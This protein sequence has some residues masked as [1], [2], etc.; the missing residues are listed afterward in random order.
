M[1]NFGRALSIALAHRLNVLI[2]V[3]TAVAVALLWGGNLTAVYPVV[4]V[5]MNDQSLPEWVD[6]A[7][8]ESQMEVAENSR[9][10]EQLAQLRSAEPEAMRAQIEAEITRRRADLAAMP[11]R[12]NTKGNDVQIAEKTRLKNSIAVLEGLSQTPA[13]E[14]KQKVA[15]ESRRAENQV[16]V[17]QLRAARFGWLAP[18]AHRWMP[19]TPFG[20]LMVVCLFVLICTLLRSVFRIWNSVVVARLGNLVGFDLRTLFYH[21]VLRLDVASFTEQGRG[22]LMNRCT[23]DLNSVNQGVQRLFGQTLLEPL[24]VLVCFCIAAYVSWRL[25][26]LTIIIAPLAGY[27][28]HWLGRALK[29]T[30]RRAMQ[31]LSLIY[32]TLAETLGGIKLIKAFTMEAAEKQRFQL[33]S[34][35]LYRRQMRIATYNSLVSP[36]VEALGVSMVLLASI[37][38]GY[39]VLGQHTHILGLKISD[40]ALTHGDMSVFFAMLAGMSDPARRLSNEF[41]HIQ[42]A[43]AAAD[44]VYEVLDRQPTIVDPPNPAPLPPLTRGLRLE[45]VNFHYHADKPVLRDVN[46]EVRAGETLAFVGANGCGKTTLLQLLPRFY[47]PTAG[48]ITID[49]VDIRDVR[50]RELRLRIG[51]VSQEILLFNDTVA[52][53]IAYGTA[54][55]SQE[56]IEAAARKAHAH[57]FITEKLSGGYRT[58]VGPGGSRLSGGQRQRISLARA[59]LRDPE[60]LLLDEA[61]SQIDVESEQLIHQ[62]LEVFSRDRTTLM[63]TH[64]LSMLSIADRVAV[65]D[66]GRILDVG[67]HA[68]LLGRCDLYRRLCHAGY[69]E[70]A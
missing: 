32:E 63:I 6:Q 54:G 45:G 42:Q 43:A 31:E 27:A 41:S 16:L 46:L 21:Q 11:N 19:A 22:D 58:L 17:Y 4:Q 65:M 9:W 49:G 56:A 67:T 52:N 55:V 2:C 38:G 69:R 44:R 8:A 35:E 29:R 66:Q 14:I 20:T 18:L 36:V 60:I 13:A 37:M 51:L 3:L 12:S 50:L 61:T 28:I 15:A 48:R 57:A 10:I 39:L 5:I 40:I 7:L 26:L 25:L 30:H 33:S 23:S 34:E 68:E 53:N 1:V 47:D 64:R 70:S 24:K 59:I 62:V